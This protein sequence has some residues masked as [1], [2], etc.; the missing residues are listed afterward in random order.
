MTKTEKEVKKASDGFYDALNEMFT[1]DV[2]PMLAVW[3]HADDITQMGPFGGIKRGWDEVRGE[4]EQASKMTK[5]GHIAT[6]D[7]LIRTVGN[8]AYT[9][10]TEEGENIDKD[11]NIYPVNIRATSIYR[12]EKGAWKLAH[13]HTDIS[14]G[15]KEGLKEIE[16][17]ELAEKARGEV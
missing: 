12:K 5:G 2:K 10:C 14:I 8:L 7:L 13:H 6:K 4:F 11:G 17:T 9:I 16:T 15:L 1:G 3:S